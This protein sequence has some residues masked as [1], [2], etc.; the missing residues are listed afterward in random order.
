MAV[1][2]SGCGARGLGWSAVCTRHG[3]GA[4]PPSSSGAQGPDLWKGKEKCW[5]R[6]RGLTPAPPQTSA[7][8]PGGSQAQI[9]RSFVTQ[10]CWGSGEGRRG[11]K[12]GATLQGAPPRP[13]WTPSETGL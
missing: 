6:C 9:P 10:H 12:G 2:S 13:L 4:W 8:F 11:E 1:K 5:S 3:P 7:S